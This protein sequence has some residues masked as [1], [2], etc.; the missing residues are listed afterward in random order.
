MM[1]RKVLLL[2]ILLIATACVATMIAYPPPPGRGGNPL[3]YSSAARRSRT[4]VGAF[5]LWTRTLGWDNALYLPGTMALAETL[6]SR[7]LSRDLATNNAVAVLH[8]ELCVRHD[9]VGNWNG[10]EKCEP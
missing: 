5:L 9:A 10:V 6:R 7:Q 2:E 3:E 8:D 1:T 4:E